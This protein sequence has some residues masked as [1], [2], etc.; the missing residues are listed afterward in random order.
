MKIIPWQC[1]VCGSK[2][3][4]PHGGLCSRCNKAT[5]TSCLLHELGK[6]QPEGKDTSAYICRS[7]ATPE[8]LKNAAPLFK[9]IRIKSEQIERASP[10][11]KRVA[12]TILVLLVF[13]SLIDL[14]SGFYVL[15]HSK[16]IYAGLA[17]LMV[18]AVF[19]Y[20]RRGWF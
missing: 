15:R 4:T 20:P 13:G 2:F 14:F 5:C 17:A 18:V 12:L 9:T 1:H 19:L 8:E 11:L 6:K 10:I 16:S 7:C 3:D